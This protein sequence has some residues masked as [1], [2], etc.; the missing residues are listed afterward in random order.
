M[1]IIFAGTPEFAAVSLRALLNTPHTITAVLTQPDRP[2]GRGRKHHISPVKSVAL[3]A[4]IPVLQ[5]EKLN[6]EA[7]R[8]LTTYPCDVM[9]VSAYGLIIPQAILSWPRRGC[10]N[11][12]ASLLPRWRGAAPIQRAILAGDNKTGISLMQMDVGLDTGAILATAPTPI[13][14]RDTAASLHDRLATLGATLLCDQLNAISNGAITTT[15]QDNALACY[16]QKL[17]KTE[18]LIDWSQSATLIDRRI[19][20]LSPWPGCFTHLNH[21][22]IKIIS[23]SV[24]GLQQH[25]SHPPGQLIDLTSN[26]LGVTTGDGILRIAQLQLEGAKAMTAQD[27]IN[28]HPQWLNTPS[29]FEAA[30]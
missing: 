2:H 15:P 29:I 28:G 6:P 17:T 14:D 10:V 25:A 8:L 11:I 5:P 12:H 16:A 3:D 9:I 23:A 20:G 13:R 27:A 24:D 4:Q 22:R 18:G 26:G 30:P 19:R 7:Q 21:R 1:N